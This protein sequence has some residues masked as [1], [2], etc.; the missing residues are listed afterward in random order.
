MIEFLKSLSPRKILLSFVKPALI[1][2]VVEHGDKLQEEVKKAIATG[3]PGAV[4]KVFD[5]AQAAMVEKINKL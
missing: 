3:G 5:A 1:N 4:D 2:L